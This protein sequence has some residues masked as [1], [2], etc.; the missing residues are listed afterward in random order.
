MNALNI[1]SSPLLTKFLLLLNL[2]YICSQPDQ[3]QPLALAP[4]L[5]LPSIDHQHCPLSKLQIVLFVMQHHTSGI[6]FLNLSAS[7]ILNSLHLLI[8]LLN[9]GHLSHQHHS[10]SPLIFSTPNSPFPLSLFHHRLTT[11]VHQELPYQSSGTRI[12][13]VIFYLSFSCILFSFSHMRYI[14]PVSSQ[15][16]SKR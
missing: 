14:K 15:L 7:L 3:S 2:S 4:R 8:T 9:R 6:S 1:R 12:T 5:S 10:P 13:V 16:L 11:R